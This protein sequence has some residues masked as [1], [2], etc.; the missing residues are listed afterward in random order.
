LFRSFETIG[1]A[2][3][4]GINSKVN[5][6]GISFPLYV[7]IGLLAIVIPCMV[8][9]VM[10]VPAQPVDHDDVADGVQATQYVMDTDKA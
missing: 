10:L 4:Y 6:T 2:I 8:G 9:L 5:K 1:Q 3:S 7:N